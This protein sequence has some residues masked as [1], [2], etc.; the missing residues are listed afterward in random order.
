MLARTGQRKWS[1]VGLVRFSNPFSNLKKILTLR[2]EESVRNHRLRD[3]AF[4]YFYASIRGLNYLG[5]RFS[6]RANPFS[7]VCLFDFVVGLCDICNQHELIS[8]CVTGKRSTGFGKPDFHGIISMYHRKCQTWDTEWIS[9]IHL[10]AWNWW[11]HNNLIWIKI[12][13][14]KKQ[15]LG[16]GLKSSLFDN[17]RFRP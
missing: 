6:I 4:C 12:A 17:L 14:N 1:V 2:P 13:F 9:H 5:Y 11:Y 8:G 7:G 10:S 15:K 16:F 3:C